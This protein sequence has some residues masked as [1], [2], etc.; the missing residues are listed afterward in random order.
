M[1]EAEI[2]KKLNMIESE[3]DHMKKHL[4]DADLMI[5]DDDLEA[6]KE[7]EEDL[8]NKRTVRIA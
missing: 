5:T 4:I 2:L 6:L 7:G 1:S 8:R 3:L